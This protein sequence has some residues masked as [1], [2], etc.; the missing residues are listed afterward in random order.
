MIYWVVSTQLLWW[1]SVD[2][3]S[4]ITISTAFTLSIHYGLTLIC[5][6]LSWWSLA[7]RA[8]AL[9]LRLP[10]LGGAFSKRALANSGAE[11]L[12]LPCYLIAFGLCRPLSLCLQWSHALHLHEF[13]PEILHVVRVKISKGH[14]KLSMRVFLKTSYDIYSG[15][16]DQSGSVRLGMLQHSN[17]FGIP[18]I[19]TCPPF[20]YLI[21][22]LFH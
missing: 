10:F 18:P 2:V 12:T 15:F 16:P 5:W 14:P 7:F 8:V 3:S 20:I 4:I 6:C 22:V 17:S 21:V 11:N 9:Y 19:L 1:N 13:V